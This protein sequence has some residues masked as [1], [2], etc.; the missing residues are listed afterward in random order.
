[1][2]WSS[3]Y[4]FGR[5]TWC[6]TEVQF[7]VHFGAGDQSRVNLASG[8]QRWFTFL[9][10]PR[11]GGPH[12]VE[13]TAQGEPSRIIQVV[14]AHAD[15]TYDVQHLP[16]DVQSY[17]EDAIKVLRVGVPDA[18]A[19]QLR[20]TLEAAASHFETSGKS[21]FENV[22]Q[23]I[24]KGLITMQFSE[25]L[26]HIRQVGNIGAHATDERLDA[27][28][29]ERALRFTTQLLRNLFEVP[30]ELASLTTDAATTNDAEAGG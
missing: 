21:L 23:L 15:T 24:D 20:R 10:C 3:E 13:H 18:A 26:T 22:K 7:V 5:C 16:N 8:R 4:G 14:P 25:A 17:Y 2:S 27:P 28:A 30:A 6:E 9:T 12:V 19:V 1:M 11:C 29:V